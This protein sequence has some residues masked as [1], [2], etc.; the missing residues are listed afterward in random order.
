MMIPKDEKA[1][2]LCFNGEGKNPP[3]V[4]RLFAQGG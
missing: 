4:K 2:N 1:A 3:R